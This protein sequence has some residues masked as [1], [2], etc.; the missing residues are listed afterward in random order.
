MGRKKPKDK[1]KQQALKR[2]EEEKK[3]DKNIQYYNKTCGD[4]KKRE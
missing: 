1:K 3:I 4:K 2:K